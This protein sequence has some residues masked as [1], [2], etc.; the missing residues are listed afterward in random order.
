LNF[1]VPAARLPDGQ[2][3]QEFVILNLFGIWN[4]VLEILR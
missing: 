1:A 2:G 4:L 3:R